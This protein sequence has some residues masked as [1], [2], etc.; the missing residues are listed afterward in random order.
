MPFILRKGDCKHLRSEFEG[1]IFFNYRHC[2][3]REVLSGYI[4]NSEKARLKL[5][6]SWWMQDHVW[7][8]TSL[9]VL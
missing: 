6:I 1:F 4:R 5:D 9:F 2:R 8:V 3:L 7:Q